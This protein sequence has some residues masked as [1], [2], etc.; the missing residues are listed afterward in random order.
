MRNN[1]KMVQ[2]R[3]EYSC[4]ISR[5][6]SWATSGF[7]PPRLT[8]NSATVK[9]TPLHA[10]SNAE[11]GGASTFLISTSISWEAFVHGAAKWS[12]QTILRDGGQSLSVPQIKLAFGGHLPGIQTHSIA[13]TGQSVLRIMEQSPALIPHPYF[14]FDSSYPSASAALSLWPC[15]YTGF[16]ALLRERRMQRES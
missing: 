15:R 13:M 4:Q 9:M 12:E 3:P 14:N 7:R 16:T 11:I 10:V 1:G 2:Q 6:T 8:C 5:I